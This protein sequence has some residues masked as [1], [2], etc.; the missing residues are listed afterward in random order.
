[1]LFEM[2]VSLE[3][4][5]QLRKKANKFNSSKKIVYHEILALNNSNFAKRSILKRENHHCSVWVLEL[6]SLFS[7]ELRKI[8][9]CPRLFSNNVYLHGNSNFTKHQQIHGTSTRNSS[10]QHAISSL[11]RTYHR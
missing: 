3:K 8:S 1:M 5:L 7:Q 9:L 6:L 2:K 11:T 4:N 10:P